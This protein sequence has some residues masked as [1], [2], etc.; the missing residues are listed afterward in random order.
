MG[1]VSLDWI[2]FNV[3]YRELQ[4]SIAL[5]Q[6]QEPMASM[7]AVDDEIKGPR[8]P[9]S[10]NNRISFLRMSGVGCPGIGQHAAAWQVIRL[11]HNDSLPEVSSSS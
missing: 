6:D 9:S 1:G 8:T 11:L 7:K 5:V 3:T 10:S 2:S 4:Q